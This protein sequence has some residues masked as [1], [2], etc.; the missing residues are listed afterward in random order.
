M[1]HDIIK[2][3]LIQNITLLKGVVRM[4]DEW[5]QAIFE[6]FGKIQKN[7]IKVSY[8]NFNKPM[9]TGSSKIGGKPNLPEEFEWPCYEGKAYNGIVA[10]WPLSFLAQI[11]LEDIAAL[12]QD[13]KLPKTGMLSFFYEMQTEKWGYDPK[14]KGCARVFYFEDPL[15]LVKIDFPDS[16]EEDYRF[17]E[18][19]LSFEQT[20]SLPSYSSFYD[21]SMENELSEKFPEETDNFDW[22]DYNCLKEEYGCLVEEDITQFFGY[23]DVIQNPNMEQQCEEVT[24][25]IYN[26][27]PHELSDEFET[28]IKKASNDW[29][30]LFQMGT[31]Q[32]DDFELMFGDCGYIYFWIKKQ[33]LA[34]KN[35]NHIWCVLQCY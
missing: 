2:F 21:S 25:G 33:D 11:N 32:S 12:D 19:V 17:P 20:I 28:E 35:F 22:D 14:D 8:S 9:G 7:M 15:S 5:K 3:V 24:R 30:L 31:I 10:N 27:A 29:I 23:P 26:G 16:L 4:T 18:F 34:K 6:I 1:R 13:N